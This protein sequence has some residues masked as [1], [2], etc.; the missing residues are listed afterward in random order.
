MG[1]STQKKTNQLLDTQR[2]QV[3]QDYNQ[4]INTARDRSAQSYQAGQDMIPGLTDRY[5]KLADTGGFDP[6]EFDNYMSSAGGGGGNP[7]GD[8]GIDESK[9]GDAH[10]RLS[11]YGKWWWSRCSGNCS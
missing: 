10:K 6:G 9:F 3:Q 2:G 8:L 11:G 1:Q 5:N 4:P 7:G